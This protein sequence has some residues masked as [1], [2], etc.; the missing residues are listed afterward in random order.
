MSQKG[1]LS[2]KYQ[3]QTDGTIYE[4]EDPEHPG[5]DQR[6]RVLTRALRS[7]GWTATVR[8]H[9]P[10]GKFVKFSA[11]V[12][13]GDA[14][15][16][17]QVYI[18]PNLADTARGRPHEKRIQLSRSYSE[19]ANDF[20][21][22]HDGNRR[23]LL[24][25]LYIVDA[26]NL[27][28]CAWN[29]RAYIDHAKPSSCYV[30][31]HAIGNAFRS[32]FARWKD[33][34]EN[35][36]CCFRPEFIYY[37]IE[38]MSELHA[39]ATALAEGELDISESESAADDVEG[40][41]NIIYYG[42]P[43][44]GKTH[45]VDR[46]VE[47]MTCVRTVFH[48]D[49]QNSDFVGALKPVSQ[50]GH[51]SYEFSPGPFAIA[52]MEAITSPKE[53]VHLIIEELNRAPAAA[54]FGE[55]FLLLDREANGAGKYD[56]DFPNPEFQGWLAEEA[57]Y[58]KPK[59]ALPKNLWIWAT[60]NS[61]DQGVYPIDTAFRRRWDQKYVPIN[62]KEGPEG[63]FLLAREDAGE[64]LIKWLDF[65]QVVNERLT[66]ELSIAEDRL[67]GPWFVTAEELER[68]ERIPSKVLIY[69][70]DDL[71]RHHGREMVFDLSGAGTY[72]QLSERVHSG[73][74]IFSDGLQAQ[75]EARLIQPGE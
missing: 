58:R 47:G 61:A 67:L 40:G 21:L 32:G 54:V 65:V 31:I 29:A 34:R 59:I 72:G 66:R 75:L 73:R 60:M 22:P 64:A 56:A 69:L 62:Y 4:G 27:V 50:S 46:N 16:E 38:H 3:A 74:K 8:P 49:M 52:L 48:P 12:S 9:E 35:Y 17:L 57:D 10:Q 20:K 30:D 11:D 28:I 1:F 33:K 23:C 19:H 18:F 2:M 53:K 41:E 36:V 7:L 42:A 43:G 15:Y 6:R 63:S 37:Y 24:L 5:V 55:L 68:S 26:E 25:G 45:I 14:H 71:L 39:S 44:T 13:R 70:W 51:V